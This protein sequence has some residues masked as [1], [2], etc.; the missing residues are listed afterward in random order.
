MGFSTTHLIM[1]SGDEWHMSNAKT[2]EPTAEQAREY[3]RN[4]IHEVGGWPE[5]WGGLIHKTIPSVT[6]GVRSLTFTGALALFTRVSIVIAAAVYPILV[7]KVVLAPSAVN[8]AAAPT[9]IHDGFVVFVHAIQSASLIDYMLGF[10]A[11]FFVGAPKLL[12]M[13][14]KQAKHE[15]HAPFNELSAAIKGLPIKDKIS[16]A[17]TV[18]AIR[19][20]LLALCEEMSLLIGGPAGQKVTDVT[21]L[22]FCDK[23]GK[24]MQVRCRT[25]NHEAVGRP[26]D[27][28][29]FVAYY[30]ALEGRNFAEQDFKNGRNP[31]PA[32]R[33][34]V[35]G[36]HDIE[37]RSVLYMP[38]VCSERLSGT[39]PNGGMVDIVDS[40]VGVICVHS[41]KAYRFWRWGDHAK[42]VGGFS[43]VAFSRSMPYI[44]LLE[45]LL[46]H[47]AVKVKLELT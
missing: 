9:T 6:G 38:I 16:A 39:Q 44:V 10:A 14:G 34:T 23:T 8:S 18:E 13:F 19:L 42:G 1:A 43:D 29:K 11:I 25:N 2:K 33:V 28:T 12:D 21:L 45:R 24:R 31:F 30:V 7:R 32:K 35:K 36:D 15:Q 3:V 40:C 41:A 5:A 46:S 26:I 37:Y 47:T 20:T 22:E 4:G 17:D 27:S